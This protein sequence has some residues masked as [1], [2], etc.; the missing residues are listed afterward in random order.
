MPRMHSDVPGP[1][2]LIAD[3]HAIFAEA[4]KVYLEPKFPVLG[5]VS[6]GRALLEAARRLKPDVVVVDVAMP[7]LNGLDAARK[8]KKEISEIK[9]VFLTMRDDPNLAAAALELGSIAFVLKHSTGPELITAIDH[10]LRGQS[11]LTPKLRA[12]DWVETQARARQYSKELTSRQ[13][14]IVQLFAE[15]KSMK[16][17][18][19]ILELSEKTV[20][21]HK[22][23]IMESHNLKSN[24][25]LI[26]FALRLGL[27]TVESELPAR[28]AAARQ[29]G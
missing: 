27:I 7:L 9:F 18:A 4:L 13:R 21:F 24:A 15:G 22:R 14:E 25:E 16:E 8:I 1:R 20:E 5:I 11:Y 28:A 17:I 29:R 6:N 10:V 2:F 19:A 23:H 12:G 26:L 3:D